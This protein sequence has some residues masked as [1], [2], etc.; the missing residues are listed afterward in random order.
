MDEVLVA[1]GGKVHTT[2]G[3][4]YCIGHKWPWIFREYLFRFK[5]SNIP[6]CDCGQPETTKHVLKDC[7]LFVKGRPSF[8]N[9]FENTSL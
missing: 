3:F 9:P 1:S 6:L 8:L 5:R 2:P 4:L 7:N